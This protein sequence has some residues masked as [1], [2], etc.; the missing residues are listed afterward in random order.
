MAQGK[1]VD[2]TLQDGKKFS[3]YIP[4][5]VSDNTPIFYY[6]YV[7]G[8]EKSTDKIWQTFDQNMLSQNPN[9]IVIIPHD[10]Q[11]VFGT[12]DLNTHLYQNNSM[13]A[14]SIIEK[15]L[16]IKPTQFVNGGFSAGFGVSVRNLAHYLKLNPNAERQTIF[17]VDGVINDSTNLYPSELQTLHDNNTIVIS[18]TQNRNHAYQARKMGGLPI[19]YVVDPD[20]PENSNDTVYWGFHDKMTQ[21]F[22]D[23][24]LYYKLIDFVR[25]EGELPEGYTYRYYN[26]KDGKIYK[27]DASNASELLGIEVYKIPTNITFKDISSLADFTIKSSNTTFA[28]HLNNIKNKIV[29]SSI[30]SNTPSTSDMNSTTSIPSEIPSVYQEYVSTTSNL[31]TKLTN[32]ILQFSKVSKSI[33]EINKDLEKESEDLNAAVN[34]KSPVTTPSNDYYNST[35]STKNDWTTTN[36]Q[37]TP[38]YYSGNYTG[39]NYSGTTGSS[40]PSSGVTNVEVNDDIES[41]K[42]TPEITIPE[43]TSEEYDP[44]TSFP[45]FDEVCTDKNRLVYEFTRN[46]ETICKVVVHRD[47]DT[48]TGVEHYYDF[49][50]ESNAE[51]LLSEIQE[52]YKNNEHLDKIIQEGQYIKVIFKKDM[53][54]K[55]N[56]EAL[57][58]ICS[59]KIDGTIGE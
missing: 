27:I 21:E 39:N 22:F 36:N 5:E 49:K 24:G 11:L 59:P 1:I 53:Y 45:E 16:G 37:T 54:S 44:L 50:T 32:D 52:D 51:N 13:E 8:S 17:A 42:P 4:T 57:K 23:Q 40:A 31:L 48:V 30:L 38:S 3:A 34:I 7:V 14:L 25:G 18:Y 19:L 43:E 58:K 29:N 28:K 12:E 9:A 55:I 47:G 46:N 20:V 41:T 33:D 35:Q 56:L 26:P 10:R 2:Y 6:S 15:D